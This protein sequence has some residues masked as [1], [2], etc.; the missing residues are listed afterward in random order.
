MAAEVG[1]AS[2]TRVFQSPKYIQV[3]LKLWMMSCT[4][5]SYCFGLSSKHT[6]RKEEEKKKKKTVVA[7]CA[8]KKLNTT[9]NAEQRDQSPLSTPKASH[10]QVPSKDDVPLKDDFRYFHSDCFK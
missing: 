10:V 9:L 2:N 6:F 8:L 3:T 5:H 1:L 7:P 4:L